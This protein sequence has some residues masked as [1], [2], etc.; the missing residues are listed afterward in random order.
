VIRRFPVARIQMSSGKWRHAVGR[1]VPTLRKIGKRSLL[2][3]GPLI[4][5]QVSLYKE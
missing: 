5:I 2:S 1:N 4:K 3:N